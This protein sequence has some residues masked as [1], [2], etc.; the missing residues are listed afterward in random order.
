MHR[1]EEAAFIAH[2]PGYRV[3]DEGVEVFNA[4][5]CEFILEFLIENFLEDFLEAAVVGF[6]DGV[7]GGEPDIDVLGKTVDEAG[8]GEAF[9]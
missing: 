4:R 7:L 2:D 8:A 5:F 9:N 3:V 6:R 1:P